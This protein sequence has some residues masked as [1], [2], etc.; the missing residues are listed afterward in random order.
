MLLKGT[1]VGRMAWLLTLPCLGE[2]QQLLTPAWGSLHLAPEWAES[3][4]VAL[5]S[6]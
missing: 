3:S 4:A 2:E 1:Q 5:G 6:C